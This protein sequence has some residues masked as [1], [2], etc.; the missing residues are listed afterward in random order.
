MKLEARARFFGSRIDRIFGEPFYVLRPVPMVDPVDHYD[1]FP[2]IH[3]G[4]E[5]V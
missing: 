4:R 3:A 1:P 2:R 5:G